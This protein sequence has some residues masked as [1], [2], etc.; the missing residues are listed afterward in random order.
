MKIKKEQI[1][2]TLPPEWPEDLL[3]TIQAMVQASEAKIV[4]LDDDPTGNQTVYNVPVL[5]EWSPTALGTVL[6]EPGAIVYV[7]TNSRSLS[8]PQAQALNR[9]IASNLRAASTATGRD[10]VVV[11]R[12]DSTL[13][14]HYPGEVDALIAGLDQSFDGTLI[15]PFFAEGGRLT[16]HDTHYV[17][18]GDW[19]L[20]AAETEYARDAT[21]GYQN[22]NLRAWVCEKHQGKIQPQDVITIPLTD[23][24]S[25]GP[26]VV[27]ATLNR[28]SAGGICTVNVV[29]YRDMEVFVVGL[30]QVEAAGKRFVYRT[31]ASFVRVRGG[32]APRSL[33]TAA[34]LAVSKGKKAGLIIVGSHVK[35]STV[36]IEAAK[37][38]PGMTPLAVSVAKLLDDGG[39]DAEIR[40]VVTRVNEAL[41][42]GLDTLVYTSRELVTGS[43]HA[44]TLQIGQRI[45][46]GLVAIVDHLST[47]PAWL[48]AKGG[49][50]A[51]DIATKG[52]GVQ[53]A[54]VLGQALPGI[55]IW[56]T[57]QESRW[58]G[59]VY[60]VF[61]GNVGGPAALAE[62]VQ[63][64]RGEAAHQQTPSTARGG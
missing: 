12:S 14:G 13:R 47:T 35:K 59:L 4:V 61:P 11:S 28:V 52:L 22:S 1:L 51:S 54:E 5:T 33:L 58:P 53:R 55:P 56:R 36:Q 45:S 15:I 32:L 27:A 46:T 31:A 6:A 9:E 44:S 39:R 25:G 16:V 3:P 18:E 43:D 7:L 8:L 29:T 50:T 40:R 57:G 62:M 48:I 17:T 21:F 38:L 41:G 49:I 60:V 42:A 20:P 10:F 30:L 37:S 26:E 24:R 2:S 63:I 23:L 64:L 19:L 34:D